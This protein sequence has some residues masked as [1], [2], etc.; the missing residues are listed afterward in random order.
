MYPEPPQKHAVYTKRA[1]TL[2]KEA[3]VAL[4][5][6]NSAFFTNGIHY[7]LQISKPYRLEVAN[8]TDAAIRELMVPTAA[9]NL[10]PFLGLRNAF[11][12]FFR[13]FTR[14]ASPLSKRLKKAE[15]RVLGLLIK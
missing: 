10:Y 6:K 12:Q 11:I 1:L 5:L 3:E 7:L 14:T 9:T 8:Y 15:E 2:L 13:N 4:K